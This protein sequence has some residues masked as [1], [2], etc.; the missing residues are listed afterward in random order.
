[1]K[2]PG[3]TFENKL[4]QT[5]GFSGEVNVTPKWKL[6]VTSGYDFETNKLSYTS[7]TVYRDLHCWEM[8]FNW[9]PMGYLKSWNF[10]IKVKA[11]VLQ[12]LKLNRKKDLRDNEY[13]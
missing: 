11:E 2:Y 9:I 8:R 5:L 12:D 3:R 4:V 7:M 6:N 1:L 10:Y 13:Y